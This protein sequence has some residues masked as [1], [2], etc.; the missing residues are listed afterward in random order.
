MKCRIGLLLL[1]VFLLMSG[2]GK[3]QD[4]GPVSELTGS[5]YQSL[6]QVE[7]TC[8]LT[9]DSGVIYTLDLY[10]GEKELYAKDLPGVHWVA[11]P[12]VQYIY[13][14][15][16]HTLR[17]YTC[18]TGEDEAVCTIDDIDRLYAATED[19]VL[20]CSSIPPSEDEPNVYHSHIESLN[21]STLETREEVGVLGNLIGTAEGN[22]VFYSEGET[23]FPEDG[24]APKDQWSFGM[25]DLDS[26]EQTMYFEWE[27]APPFEKQFAVIGETVYFI[28]NSTVYSMPLTGGEKTPI[29]PYTN[30]QRLVPC[31]EKGF[32]AASFGPD[33]ATVWYY[34]ASAGMTDKLC[35]ITGGIKSLASDGTRYAILTYDYSGPG[36]IILGDI[37]TASAPNN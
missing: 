2:C 9:D 26:G 11:S 16:G 12:D 29:S 21:L 31:G 24:S 22:M 6:Y 30:N 14:M 17:K 10:T 28:H 8:Y 20:Y 13:Y 1:A 36:K 5:G 3:A 18:T 4:S 35:E 34:D 15:D 23:I 19:Y 32:L 7:D 27:L 33:A 37:Q 25:K